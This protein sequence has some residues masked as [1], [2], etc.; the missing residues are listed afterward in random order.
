MHA[1]YH[2]SETLL[3][4]LQR[5][6]ADTTTASKGCTFTVP[7]SKACNTTVLQSNG[8]GD[9]LF[10]HGLQGWHQKPTRTFMLP[11]R[12]SGEKSGF[13]LKTEACFLFLFFPLQG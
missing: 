12:A 1:G 5:S 3:R 9:R 4:I 10:V 7:Q 8:S 13:M 6:T 11:W 2:D